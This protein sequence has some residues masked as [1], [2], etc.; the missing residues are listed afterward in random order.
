M[1]EK[2]Q[3]ISKS[4]IMAYVNSDVILTNSFYEAAVNCKAYKHFL[5][6]GKRYNLQVS[7]LMEY[8][9]SWEN[10]L[11]SKVKKE[12][13]LHK[14]T[15]IDYFVFK[16]LDWMEMPPFIV[17]RVAWDNWMVSEALRKGHKV[18]DGTE[19]VFVVH[20]NHRYAQ[21]EGGLSIQKGPE[22]LINK[23]VAANNGGLVKGFIID[24][25]WKMTKTGRITQ[26]Q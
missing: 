21:V 4:L 23:E 2:A 9:S 22:A 15:G 20:Q 26:C 25:T 13:K 11:R 5:L 24:A 3:T 1:F 7:K 12:G 10:Q 6:I 8:G 14:H 18:I 17:G 19:F 16:R